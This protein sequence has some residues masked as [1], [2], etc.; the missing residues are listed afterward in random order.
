LEEIDTKGNH[1]QET[2]NKSTV[3]K[4]AKS[5]GDA[6]SVAKKRMQKCI[7]HT[8]AFSVATKLFNL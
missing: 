2:W 8:N 4:G 1:K 6:Y 7:I 5:A 3:F